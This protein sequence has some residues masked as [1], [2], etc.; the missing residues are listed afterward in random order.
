MILK[1]MF[2]PISKKFTLIGYLDT[3]ASMIGEKQLGINTKLKLRYHKM[4]VLQSIT[5]LE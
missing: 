4:F 5:P 3:H 2:T 1:T